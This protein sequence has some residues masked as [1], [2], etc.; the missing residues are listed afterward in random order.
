V[1]TTRAT[2]VA[3]VTI[4]SVSDS[5]SVAVGR[6]LAAAV[7]L[8][9]AVVATAL[10]GQV[11]ST[12]PSPT[13]YGSV[14]TAFAVL[15]AVVGIAL[16]AAALLLVS[17]R[18]TV[19]L[20][21]LAV[22]A[23]VAWFA[24]V[25]VGWEGGPSAV[26]GLGQLAAPLL[27]AVVLAI[28]V[29]IA[30]EASAV[31]RAATATIATL[32]LLATAAATT[33]LVVVREPIR[34]RGCWSDCTANAFLLHDDPGLA[35]RALT[36]VL[37]LGVACGGL[38]SLV[39]FV[40]FSRVV[41]MTRRSAGPALAGTAAT[42]LALAA[43]AAASLHDTP[44]AADR[45]PYSALFVARAL[46]L[47]ALAAGL[48]WLALRPRLVRGLV[49]RLAVDLERSAPAGG[50]GRM[51]AGALAD[52]E[53]R[54]G[55]PI[56]NDLEL[57]DGEGRPLALAPGRRVTP[58]VGGDGGVVALVESDVTTPE[59]LG[60]ALGPAAHVA[61]GNERLRA[62]TLA[63]LADVT[64]SRARIVETADAARRRMERDLHD[65]AQQ[66]IL[67]LTYDLRIAL[68]MAESSGNG[69]VGE[70]RQA[71]DR[72]VAASTELRDV[73]HGIFPAELASSGLAAA[74]ESLADVRPVR[75]DVGLVPGRRYPAEVEAAAY[76]VVVEAVEATVVEL[77]VAVR[78]RDGRLAIV[79]GG[80]TL[81]DPALV[82]IEDRVGA[83]GG[84]IAVAGDRL[85]VELPHGFH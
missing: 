60:D 43:Y 54:L 8:A 61:L 82:R 50:L 81:P 57:V 38:A 23:S 18:T 27:P 40:R 66:R 41:A 11:T 63:R 75:L 37:W 10:V 51:L 34:D 31:G 13:T 78:E 45:L 32:A 55:Y 5:H 14:S 47:L 67:A 44:E 74:L 52:P 20:G 85:E 39:A 17:E 71:F 46:S 77:G 4:E 48:G 22:A 62:E 58:I 24:P 12:A 69:H 59:A 65:G 6:A 80:A 68:E 25:A 28:A 19:L 56:G 21:V 76:A 2:N 1:L 29:C 36:T 79:I 84:A 72:A 16:L 73:A 53:L 83:A 70:L 49:T 64:E 26:R 3:D 33:T 35:H 30:P 42:G 9:F 7:A 15:E